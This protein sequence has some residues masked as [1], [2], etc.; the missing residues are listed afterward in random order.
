MIENVIISA[1]VTGIMICQRAFGH[2]IQF[3][4]SFFD[5][6]IDEHGMSWDEMFPQD[7]YYQLTHSTMPMAHL[8]L[9]E[10]IVDIIRRRNLADRDKLK[11]T[12]WR[13]AVATR[14]GQAQALGD[15]TRQQSAGDQQAQSQ[16]RGRS[17]FHVH[18]SAVSYY[19][20]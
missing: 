10:S 13:Q 4:F 1:H 6:L 9:A 18:R 14:T 20:V 15:Q 8:L 2:W 17:V 11:S 16:Q 5:E 3:Y 12:K 7:E 19:K